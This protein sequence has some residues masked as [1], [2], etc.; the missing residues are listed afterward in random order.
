MWFY[1]HII[2]SII[3]DTEELAAFAGVW[4]GGDYA[5]S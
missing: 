1:A 2:D 5:L 4:G 3:K